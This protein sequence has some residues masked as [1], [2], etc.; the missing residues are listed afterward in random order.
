MF[1][2]IIAAIAFF[3]SAACSQP[4]IAASPQIVPTITALK[5][6]NF[7]SYG[8][9]YVQGYAAIGDGGGGSF[10]WVAGSLPCN[11]V[12]GGGD[13]GTTF[14]S[15]N[16]S[17]G[18]LTTGYW[19]RQLTNFTYNILWFGADPTGAAP[20]QVAIQAAQT[21]ACANQPTTPTNS[22]Q[23]AAAIYWP[24][25]RY[26]LTAGV[27]FGACY[28]VRNYGDGWQTSVIMFRPT[29]NDLVALKCEEAGAQCANMEVDHLGFYSDDT[30]HRKTALAM[31]DTTSSTVH[32]VYCSGSFSTGLSFSWH[33][34]SNSSNCFLINGRDNS[35]MRTIQAFADRPI[36]FGVNPN[37]AAW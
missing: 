2:K 1:R 24:R 15:G 25:G 16:G 13:G 20:S 6:G 12:I 22:N 4:A 31:V 32:D 8:T 30:T 35:Q 28:R 23:L 21:T 17:G 37:A 14:C 7:T 3:L 19:K 33:D 18:Y 36:Y 5:A 9:L 34:S 26:L 10:I 11:S 29:A 27:T